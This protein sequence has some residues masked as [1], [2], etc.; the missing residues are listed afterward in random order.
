MKISKSTSKKAYVQQL[1]YLLV[2]N[3]CLLIE[4]KTKNCQNENATHMS[5]QQILLIP[6]TI[7]P[8]KT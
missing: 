1:N 8:D 4:N 3:N 2:E 5:M 6:F 7:L